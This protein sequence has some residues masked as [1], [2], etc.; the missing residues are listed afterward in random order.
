MFTGDEEMN[1][2]ANDTA[3]IG[4]LEAIRILNE[5]LQSPSELDI[6]LARIQGAVEK[7]AENNKSTK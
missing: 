3:L 7:A 2:E 1:A 6:A 5:K 4:L